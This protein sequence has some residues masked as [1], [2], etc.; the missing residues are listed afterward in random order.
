MGNG[1]RR[2]RRAGRPGMTRPFVIGVTGRIASGKSTVLAALAQLGAETI[3]ADVVY[4]DLIAP[5][6]SLNR[7][8]QAEFGTAIA[9]ADG[10][11]GRKALGGIVFDD[12][13]ALARLDAVTH[14]A[15]GAEI[16][17]RIQASDAKV[18]AVDAVKLLESELYRLCDRIWFVTVDRAT[19]IDRLAA[20]NNI[21]RAAAAARV[22]AHTTR[23]ELL[24]LV[25]AE[26]DN[27]GSPAATRER[28][29]QLWNEIFTL[30]IGE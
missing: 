29:T 1:L 21:S 26:I 5:G 22:D 25:D 10:A 9:T 16:E 13:A 14:P 24:D 6:S 17:R 19:Q 27:N 11:I 30:P 28:V 18:V 8:L 4:H 23:S 15:V 3:D 20:R 12:P 2:V 7:A